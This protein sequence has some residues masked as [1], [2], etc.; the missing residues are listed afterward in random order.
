MCTF[1]SP[2]VRTR[3]QTSILSRKEHISK[4]TGLEEVSRR[5]LTSVWLLRDSFL[6]LITC[7][8]DKRSADF[9]MSSTDRATTTWRTTLRGF[10][11]LSQI[12]SLRLLEIC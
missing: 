11:L 5:W 9:E 2:Q 6:K 10:C 4:T 8:V 7:V 3:H 12:T 1:I